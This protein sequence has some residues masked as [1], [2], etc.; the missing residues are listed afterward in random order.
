MSNA[1]NA[2]SNGQPVPF[3]IDARKK[4]KLDQDD[5]EH[6]GQSIDH[7][8]MPHTLQCQLQFHRLPFHHHQLHKKL[9]T[10]LILLQA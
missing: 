8:S 2:A 10:A 1:L 9:V 6:C 3:E 7:F 4:P 5:E